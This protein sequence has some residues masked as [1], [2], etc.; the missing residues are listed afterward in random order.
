MRDASTPVS[1]GVLNVS[2]HERASS[3][4]RS[5]NCRPSGHH[6][7]VYLDAGRVSHRRV[8]RR[9]KA[10]WARTTPRCRSTVAI[11]LFAPGFSSF[12][13]T[14]FSTAST[15]PSRQRMPI[16]VPPVSTALTAYST[17][18]LRPS[19]EKIELARVVASPY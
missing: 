8:L 1:I 19:G 2:R 17:W 16:D 9:R 15:T 14:T 4:A 6:A 5:T 7:R 11:R 12:D 10:S 13:P 18:K 3:R